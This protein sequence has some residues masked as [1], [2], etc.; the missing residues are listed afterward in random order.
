MLY[1]RARPRYPREL[2]E[3]LFR[4]TGLRA[5]DRVLEIGCGTGQM[6]L[7]LAERGVRL[8]ALEP[9]D[10]LAALARRN[11]AGH[12]AAQVVESTFEAYRLP[13]APFDLVISA[14]AFHWI[15]PE[16]RVCKAAEALRP[17]GHL[18]VVETHWGAG[19]ERDPFS[20][21]SQDCYLRW[22]PEARPGFLPP[23]RKE[24]PATRP[25]LENAPAFG[26]VQRHL[27][28][29]LNRYSARGYVDLLGTFSNV[30]GLDEPA[31]AGLLTC[32]GDLVD[33][34]FA[35]TLTRSDT[36]ELWLA[37]RRASP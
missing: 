16:I 29:Q 26:S 14:T 8:I 19:P 37:R 34:E 18:A 4:L 10:A 31:R 23:T 22:D 33:R 20:V 15:D 2:V 11:L 9:G 25:E 32:L 1:D 5:G 6:T 13:D 21:R 35:G 12:P 30:R 7:P 27:Y 17:G 3:D 36:R 24:L 28:E